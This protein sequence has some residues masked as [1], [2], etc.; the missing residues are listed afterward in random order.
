MWKY[1]LIA[2]NELKYFYRADELSDAILAYEYT[3]Q[4]Y[5]DTI[6]CVMQYSADVHNIILVKCNL[7]KEKEN[8]FSSSW[9]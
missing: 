1:A 8:V 4:F 6:L 3:K 9:Q 5:Q 7:D 2:N